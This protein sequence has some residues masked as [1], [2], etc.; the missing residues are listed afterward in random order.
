[1]SSQNR[2]AYLDGLRG[3]GA[4]TVL[5]YHL[6]VEIFPITPEASALMYKLAPFNGTLAVFV[7]FIVSGFSLSIGFIRTGSRE[8]LQQILVGRYFRLV[9]PILLATLMVYAVAKFGLLAENRM[10]ASKHLLKA[11]RFAV[12]DVFVDKSDPAATPIPQLWTMPIELG[13]SILVVA[14]L[15]IIGRRNIR[16]AAYAL[17]SIALL[18]IYPPL[19]TFVIGI[20]FAE[21]SAVKLPHWIRHACAA[22]LAYALI[23]AYFL[24][25]HGG[26]NYIAVAAALTF[27]AAFT[28]TGRKL[29]SSRLS[30][31]MGEIS[32]PLYLLH[33]LVIWSYGAWIVTFTHTRTTLLVANLSTVLLALF[34]AWA[35]R[36]IDTMGIRCARLVS[37]RVASTRFAATIA[38][39][40]QK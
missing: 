39:L 13:G 35:F 40:G 9:V 20:L 3:W 2:V 28:E 37:Q 36:G 12:F 17:A 18:W 7:F 16:Y 34:I 21:L 30:A 24:P 25:G 32:F 10:E 14:I 15:W 29:L 31:F 4:L 6:F 8:R 1:M 23:G 11:L 19:L 5:L 26:L 22:S 27:A 33:G 38:E